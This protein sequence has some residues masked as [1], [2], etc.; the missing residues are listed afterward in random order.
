[1]E[2]NFQKLCIEVYF[3]EMK[4]LFF[5]LQNI[6]NSI[7]P[8]G[9]TYSLFLIHETMCKEKFTKFDLFLNSNKNDNVQ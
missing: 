3:P 2:D 9:M 8:A 7:N 4:S 5:I 1:M 6:L